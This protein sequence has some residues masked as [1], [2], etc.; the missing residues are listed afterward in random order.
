[1]LILTTDACLRSWKVKWF[2]VLLIHTVYETENRTQNYEVERFQIFVF[3]LAKSTQVLSL[4]SVSFCRNR[5]DLQ[6]QSQDSKDQTNKN[7]NI[8]YLINVSILTRINVLILG[9]L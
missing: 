1:M 9:F 2:G 5:G 6:V 4:I 8:L 7:E 3:V